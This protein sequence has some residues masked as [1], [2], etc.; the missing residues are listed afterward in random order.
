MVAAVAVRLR[1]T[2]PLVVHGPA[3]APRKLPR[4]PPMH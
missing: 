3:S 4:V 1:A 2:M